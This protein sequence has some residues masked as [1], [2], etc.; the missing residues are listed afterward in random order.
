MSKMKSMMTP[1]YARDPGLEAK[2][3][4]G[5]HAQRFDVSE[6]GPRSQGM[7][8]AAGAIGRGESI[9]LPTDTVYGI[10]CDPFQA[11]AVQG[12]LALKGRTR[13]MP[14]PVLVPDLAAATDL[15]TSF[16]DSLTPAL[17][18][19]WP[20]G[21]TVILPASPAVSWDLGDTGGT[22]A[23][24]MP[25]HD[26]ALELLRLVGPLAVSSANLTGQLPA[27][28]AEEAREQL[29]D[30]VAVYLDAGW[31]GQNYSDAPRHSGSTIIDASSVGAGGPWRVVRRGVVPIE[32][33]L[34]LLPGEWED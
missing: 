16:P 28:R 14:P 18:R 9:V 25:A 13:A 29:G 12:L 15:V 27:L 33:L 10:G 8:A 3:T 17:E 20:G 34:S 11:S 1:D 5:M 31:V 6:P 2:Y 19:F 24:R 21:L 22:V 26:I 4:E 30:G 23:L 32:A 7:A